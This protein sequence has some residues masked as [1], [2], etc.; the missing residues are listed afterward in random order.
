MDND[1]PLRQGETLEA[2]ANS[3]PPARGVRRNSQ[4]VLHPEFRRIAYE[5][6][7]PN[8]EYILQNLREMDANKSSGADFNFLYNVIESMKQALN[9]FN[10]IQTHNIRQVNRGNARRRRTRRRQ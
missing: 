4:G 2:P 10:M 7:K 6:I 1:I 3:P 8:F 9:S 5:E